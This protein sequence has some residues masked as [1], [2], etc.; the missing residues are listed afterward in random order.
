MNNENLLI[1]TKDNIE[2]D[3]KNYRKT[4]FSVDFLNTLIINVLFD[5]KDSF[6]GKSKTL[7]I[8]EFKE[9]I[10]KGYEVKLDDEVFR[11]YFINNND[12][13]VLGNEII[14]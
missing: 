5:V 7:L 8:N 6:K 11:N 12:F 14:F 9:R 3:K 13:K 10:Q 2:E 4:N 1:F